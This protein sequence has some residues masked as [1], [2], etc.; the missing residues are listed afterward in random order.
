M[1]QPRATP[2]HEESLGYHGGLLDDRAGQQTFGCADHA[3]NGLVTYTVG[4]F[5]LFLCA[6]CSSWRFGI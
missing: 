6:L 3:E 4:G 2:D 5:L 1:S